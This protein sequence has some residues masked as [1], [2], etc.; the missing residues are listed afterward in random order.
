LLFICQENKDASTAS[1][2]GSGNA[3]PV[4]GTGNGFI[5]QNGFSLPYFNQQKRK[6]RLMPAIGI[7][8]SKFEQLADP[9]FT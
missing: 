5:F 1:F 3:Y 7:Q 9:M 4:V 6:A 2:H 8:Y